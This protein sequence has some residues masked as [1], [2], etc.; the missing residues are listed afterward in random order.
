MKNSRETNSDMFGPS[1]G[2]RAVRSGT[3]GELTLEA[4]FK[5]YNVRATNDHPEFH[6]ETDIWG[7]TERLLIRQF[8]IQA[9]YRI[10]YLYRNFETDVRLAIECKNQIGPGTTDEKLISTVQSLV[11][12]NLPYWLI[13]SGGAFRPAVTKKVAKFIAENNQ[14]TNVPGRLIFNAAHYLQRAVERLI[15]RNEF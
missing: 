14:R 6:Y 13:L 1:Q 2:A 5:A 3:F 8:Q 7:R 4:A 15:E 11:E 12:T 10:D 9:G